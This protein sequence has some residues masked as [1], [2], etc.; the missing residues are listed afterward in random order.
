MNAYQQRAEELM[1]AADELQPKAYELL[2]SVA[3]NMVDMAKSIVPV[4][5]GRLQ[6]SI[7]YETDNL[8]DEA[9]VEFIADGHE[10]GKDSYASFVEYGTSKMAPRPYMRPAIN[11]YLGDIEDGVNKLLEDL[12]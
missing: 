2:Q 3:E 8:S 4:R 9:A 6:R 11:A 12:K 10:E 7:R 1:K 5:T